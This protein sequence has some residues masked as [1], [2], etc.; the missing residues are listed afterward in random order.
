M[1]APDI[2]V[3]NLQRKIPVNVVELQNFA[4]KAMRR[5]L[6]L[7]KRKNTD[8]RKLHEVFIWL[9]SDRRM[10]SLHRK[11]MHQTGATDVLTFQH[12]EIFISV[13]TAR[14]NAHAFRSSLARELRLYI[15]HGLLHLSGFGD[16]TQAGAQIMKKMQERI[17]RDCSGAL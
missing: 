14:R 17:L 3:R 10:A 13:E 15:V 2:S 1:T 8:L 7:H 12:G 11:F 4:A 6:Q 9:I 5:C 16:R